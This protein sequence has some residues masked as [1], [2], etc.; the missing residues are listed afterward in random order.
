[1][2]LT[3]LFT[4]DEIA[5]YE[6]GKKLSL[7]ETVPHEIKYANWYPDYW[8]RRDLQVIVKHDGLVDRWPGKQKNVYVWWELED[9]SAIGWNENP[10]KGWSFPYVRTRKKGQTALNHLSSFALDW[11][12]ENMHTRHITL[13]SPKMSRNARILRQLD[14]DLRNMQ[15]DVDKL[16]GRRKGP[17][18]H[19]PLNLTYT[20]ELFISRLFDLPTWGLIL[21]TIPLC[22]SG[23]IL[24]VVMA[25]I[26]MEILEP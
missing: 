26:I 15:A 21:I 13:Y 11:A 20:R 10:A 4:A 18:M 19:N 23:M 1:M 25:D 24:L 16:Q 2:A 8:K 9:G 6:A 14:R 12:I 5:T 7:A 17:W 3:D 22:L